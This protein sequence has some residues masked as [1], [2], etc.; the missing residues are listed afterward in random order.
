MSEDQMLK[1]L[2]AFV[3][4]YLVARMTRENGL[5]VG[6]GVLDHVG[7][8]FGCRLLTPN[9]DKCPGKSLTSGW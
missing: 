2:I 6:G 9:S 4:G 8:G 7:S 3:I 5:T 1:C